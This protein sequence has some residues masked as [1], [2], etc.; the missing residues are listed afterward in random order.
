MSYYAEKDFFDDP[1][2]LELVQQVLS[3]NLTLKWYEVE[4]TR[5]R[6]RPADPARG[7][8][9]Q[10]CNLGPYGY[11]AIPEFLRDRYSMAA[12]GSVLVEKLPDLGY[13]INRRSDV[14]ADNVAELYEEAKARRWAPAVDIPWAE[15]LAEPRPVRDAAMAQACTLLEEVALVAMEA[16]GRWVFSINQEFIEQK[17]FLCAQ[18]LDEARHV[19][20]CR[21]R[22]LVSGKGLGRASAT[23]EQALKELLSAETYPEASLGTNLLL[24]SFVLAMYRALATLADTQAD[25]LFGTLSAQD[26]ARSVAYGMGHM[27]YHLAHQ[28]G[29][30]ETLSDYLDRTEHTVVGIVGSSEF[31]EPLVLLAAGA[32]DAAALARGATFARRWFTTALEQY[33]E[34]CEAVGLTGRRQ[35][36]RLSRLAASLAA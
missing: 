28:P 8:T 29:K 15:L 12:R 32:R 18:M 16:P 13:T 1:A 19:E 26:V 14:W 11:D 9:Y 6:A 23:A 21:K 4:T 25:R 7:L 2:L 36:S 31:L 22:A 5:V 3:G 20:A 17:S 27:R 10:D 34:R 30:A 24:G 35:R 33:F